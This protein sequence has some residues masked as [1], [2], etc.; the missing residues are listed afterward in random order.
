MARAL[1]RGRD[2]PGIAK[3]TA[4]RVFLYVTARRN[5]CNLQAPAG[6]EERHA[7]LED[8]AGEF[9]LPQRFRLALPDMQRR[10]GDRH[11][12]IITERSTFRHRAIWVSRAYDIERAA[13][14]D[15]NQHLAVMLCRRAPEGYAIALASSGGAALHHKEAKGH[16]RAFRNARETDTAPIFPL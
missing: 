3:F 14:G 11:A 1:C 13:A 7:A 9:D 10:S 4:A 8:F 2:A 15:L 12:I 5:S 16:E 6:T